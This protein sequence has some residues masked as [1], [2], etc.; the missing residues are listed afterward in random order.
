MQNTHV[1]SISPEPRIET[2]DPVSLVGKRLAMTFATNRTAELWRSFM[3]HRNSIG[4]RLNGD[5]ISMQIYDPSTDFA[6]FHPGIAF[7]KWAAV[8]VS[9][10]DAVVD[11][12]EA[13]QLTG[14]LYAVFV[15]RGLPSAATPSFQYIMTDWL[16]RS[17][18]LLDN[19][20]PHFERLGSAYKGEDPDSEEEIWIPIRSR[21]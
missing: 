14:G 15:Y 8:E 10:S 3:P 16:P 17:D 18:Y 5:M 19:T 2:I 11:G 9:D 4:N 1:P 20:R 12:M 13:Y 6:A 7:E 21:R